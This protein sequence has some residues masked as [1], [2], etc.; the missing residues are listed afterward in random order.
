[1]FTFHVWIF[2]L[3]HVISDI[4]PHALILFRQIKCCE[5]VQHARLLTVQINH[6][7][8]ITSILNLMPQGFSSQG[9]HTNVR[10]L[11][12]K[13]AA[14][15]NQPF[16]KWIYQSTVPAFNSCT[17]RVGSTSV[18]YDSSPDRHAVSCAWMT[19]QRWS[20]IAWLIFKLVIYGCLYNPALADVQSTGAGIKCLY[21]MFRP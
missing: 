19:S 9:L 16:N 13:T 8:I 6:T 2:V 21:C 14:A 20:L 18:I 10:C 1:M 11:D 3:R 7:S 17:K 4:S 5:R 15:K 12:P